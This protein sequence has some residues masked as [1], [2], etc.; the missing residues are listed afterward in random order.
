VSTVPTRERANLW[1]VC[2]AQFLTLAGMTAI[3]PLLPLYLEQIGV[4]DRVAVK[5]WTG[6]LGSAPFAVA[7]F[8]TPIW[9]ALGDRFGYKPMVVRSV[10]GI[11]IATIGMGLASTPVE[12]LAWRGVQG[13]VSGVF[14]AAVALLS[15][16][17]PEERVGRALAVLQSSRAAGGLIGPVLGG[18]L[19]D[20]IGIHALFFC[21]GGLA[22]ATTLLCA[23]VLDRDPPHDAPHLRSGGRTGARSL[24]L[25]A[26]RGTV[27][28]LALIVVFQLTVMASW[29]TLALFVQ[30]FDIPQSAVASTTGLLVFAS[31]L[32]TLLTATVWARFGKRLGLVRMIAASLTLTGICNVCIGLAADRIETVL[33]LR[34]LAGL[35][36]AGFI[37]LSFEWISQ[38]APAGARGR[39]AGLGSTAM[40]LGNVIGPTLGG[41]LAVKVGLVATFWVPGLALAFVGTTLVVGRGIRH[42]L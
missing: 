7:V 40:M 9:G 2:A 42:R 6:A 15:A 3:L 28:M 39:M 26:D 10:A 27:G 38:R 23:L 31:A 22:I 30:R 19:A 13:A 34:A 1:I 41:W 11:A 17:T 25:L 21:V 32:P 20:L 12:L 24:E 35:S 5:Y 36:L 14:P 18:V 16:L 33:V 37:P 4:S 29:P 8:A